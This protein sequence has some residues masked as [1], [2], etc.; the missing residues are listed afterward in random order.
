ML[1]KG[2]LESI[3]KTSDVTSCEIAFLDGDYQIYDI[4][5]LRAGNSFDIFADIGKQC[6]LI[7]SKGS[8]CVKLMPDQGRFVVRAKGLQ[9]HLY[10]G[11][12]AIIIVIDV[13]VNDVNHC[14][15]PLKND[16]TYYYSTF[17][18]KKQ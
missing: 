10:C 15:T 8:G 3:G 12:F 17:C 18:Q 7:E 14:L 1:I 11:D 9:F 6:S 13:G 5:A 4:V 16:Y 2:S